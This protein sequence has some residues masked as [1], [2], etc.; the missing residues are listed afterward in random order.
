MNNFN[1]GDNQN[2]AYQDGHSGDPNYA[3]I[4]AMLM[5]DSGTADFSFHGTEDNKYH[6]TLN[7]CLFSL[8]KR[9]RSTF[10][11]TAS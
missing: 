4:G 10:G 3:I 9:I 6:N 11:V 5:V 1:K 7:Q 2:V 8:F